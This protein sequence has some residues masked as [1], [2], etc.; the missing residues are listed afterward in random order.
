MPFCKPVI[1]AVSLL[2]L[3]MNR[4]L[5]TIYLIYWP[6]HYFYINEAIAHIFKSAFLKCI[7]VTSL[8]LD[9]SRSI[10]LFEL[11]NT[12]CFCYSPPWSF[13]NF[14]RAG[15]GRSVLK[16]S[17]DLYLNFQQTPPLFDIFLTSMC[18][19]PQHMVVPPFSFE[20]CLLYL[21]DLILQHYL[22]HI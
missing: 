12:D 6:W 11:F 10:K 1:K 16:P 21:F 9:E 17:T 13:S 15:N 4:C 18:E 19:T 3:N 5:L 22:S 8:T 14:N 20:D 7:Q 2:S